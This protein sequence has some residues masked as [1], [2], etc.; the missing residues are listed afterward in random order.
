ME[1][2]VVPRWS[3]DFPGVVPPPQYNPHCTG[4]SSTVPPHQDSG[5]TN[6]GTK[7]N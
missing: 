6:P 5:Q 1:Q 4:C 3:V 2:V 7:T